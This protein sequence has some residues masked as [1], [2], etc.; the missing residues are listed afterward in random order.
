[1]LRSDGTC[2]LNL[3][4]SYANDGKWGGSTGGKHAGGLHGQTGIGLLKVTTGLKPKDLIGIP[5]RVALALQSDGWWL[6]S[7]IIW[8][9]PNPMPESVTDRPTKAHEYVFLMTKAERYYYDYEAVKE[10]SIDPPGKGRGG[11]LSRF[12]PTES[13]IPQN[14]HRGSKPAV[15]SGFRNKRT[16][17]TLATLPTPDAHF[18][19]FPIELPETCIIAGCPAD[20][21]VL[22]PFCGSGTTII[23]ALKNGR[24][25]VGIELNESYI[26]IARNRIKRHY[27]LFSCGQDQPGASA[28]SLPD[29]PVCA[30]DE[31]MLSG[32]PANHSACPDLRDEQPAL[33]GA[34]HE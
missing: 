17:W 10:G 29:A 3:G 25:A 19:T 9:K 1:V 34:A 2:W 23:A 20:G 6:R 5:W 13:L 11:S 8:H 15:S 27:S 12:G 4:D 33:W 18:A 22:D 30:L 21:V 24:R 26:E 14:A 32:S 7:D 28:H 16:V 31:L